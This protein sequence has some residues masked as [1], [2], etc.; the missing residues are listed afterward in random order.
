MLLH[1]DVDVPPHFRPLYD[2]K[3]EHFSDLLPHS[4]VHRVVQTGKLEVK[5]VPPRTKSYS[6]FF[7]HGALISFHAELYLEKCWPAISCERIA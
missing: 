6:F 2:T 7:C 3:H 5:M 4:P 1:K